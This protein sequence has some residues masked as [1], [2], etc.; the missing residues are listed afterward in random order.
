MKHNNGIDAFIEFEG[1]FSKYTTGVTYIGRWLTQSPESYWYVTGH[2][3]IWVPNEELNNWNE[4]IPK[5]V[6][7][8]W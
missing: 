2:T 8:L 5:G 6:Q 7:R 4:Y 3:T 1:I